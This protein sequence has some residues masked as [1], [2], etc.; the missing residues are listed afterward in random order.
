MNRHYPEGRAG[1]D[2]EGEVT[3]ALAVDPKYKIVKIVFGGP[4][5]WFGMPLEHAKL[6]RDMLNDKI[7]ELEKLE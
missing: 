1:G 2:D 3:V 7:A 6:F 5:A 4:T